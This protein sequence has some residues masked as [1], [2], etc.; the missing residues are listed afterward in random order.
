[1]RLIV[2]LIQID[3][4]DPVV[5]ALA[6]D[7]ISAT[8]IEARG[9]LLREGVAAILIGLDDARVGHALMILE[10]Y[11][12]T[13][14]TMLPDQLEESL[15]AWPSV[16]LATVEVGGTTAFILPVQQFYQFPVAPTARS[17]Q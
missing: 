17:R 6:A 9:G 16:E 13:R 12:Q 8:I 3:D 10:Q 14:R 5:H 15:G 11:C 2:A 7:Q 1:M 4:A